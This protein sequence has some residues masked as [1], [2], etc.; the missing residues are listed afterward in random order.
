MRT[1]A[2]SL[3]LSNAGLLPTGLM[4]PSWQPGLSSSRARV[5]RAVK[6]DGRQCG[7][8][9]RPAKPVG[10]T[11]NARLFMPRRR[12]V[13]PTASHTRTPEGTGVIVATA[14]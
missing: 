8:A 13:W 7:R 1:V 4:P 11:C 12:S 9:G 10:W 14:P 2:I 3:Q 5:R 6:R